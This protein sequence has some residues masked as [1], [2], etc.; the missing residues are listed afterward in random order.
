MVEFPDSNSNSFFLSIPNSLL[1]PMVALCIAA[2]IIASQSLI[3]SVFSLVSQAMALDAFPT[4]K[5]KH[6]DA[7]FHGQVYIAPACYIHMTAT[8]VSILFFFPAP[9]P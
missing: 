2:T 9:F 6:T 4:M 8:L 5:V 7:S 3:T 1:G